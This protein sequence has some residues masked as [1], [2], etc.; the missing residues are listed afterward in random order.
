MHYIIRYLSVENTLYRES[1]L[2][3]YSRTLLIRARIIREHGLKRTICSLRK[4]HHLNY[5]EIFTTFT[6]YKKSGYTSIISVHFIDYILDGFIK[7][8][9][10]V[11]RKKT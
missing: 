3:I 9:S 8:D 7:I 11:E 6:R 4:V 5:I 2:F 1:Q 10:E